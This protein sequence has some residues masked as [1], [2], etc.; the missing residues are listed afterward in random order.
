MVI[1]LASIT[2]FLFRV[3]PD[4]LR[5]QDAGQAALTGQ[6]SS[7]EE[8][9]MEGVLVSAKMTNSIVT[10]TVTSD[11]MGRYT[12]P[13]ARLQP[14]KYSLRVRAA[15]YEIDNPG[16]IEISAQKTK[17]FDLKLHKTQDLAAQLT[18]AEWFMSIP[19]TDE[20]KAGLNGCTGCQT[21]ERIMRSRY[22]AQQWPAILTRMSNYAPGAIP[23]HPQV[24]PGTQTEEGVTNSEQM[25]RRAQYLST[26]NLSS[27]RWEYVLKTLPRPKGRSTR[28]IITEYALPRANAQPHD[29]IVDKDGM[30]WY[31]DFG[32]QYIGKL[33]PKAAKA[34]EYPV[35]TVKPGFPT[36]GLDLEFDHEGNVR[37]GMM[38]QGGI[39][40]FDKKTEKFQV[41]PLPKEEGANY[42][43]QNAQVAPWWTYTDGKVWMNDVG[44]KGGFIGT[45]KGDI[46]RVDL[47]TGVWE[48]F[49]P[50]K[51]VDADGKSHFTYGIAADSH[52][53]LY[54]FD[55][56]VRNIVKDRQQDRQ[57]YGLSNPHTQ[58]DA[59]P[60]PHGL[61]GSTPVRRVS[62]QQNRDARHAERKDPGVVVANP[63]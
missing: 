30:I 42:R 48:T 9:P 46:H 62:W 29:A 55:F 33:D 25:Q 1:A 50:Y 61:A 17:Q 22:T 53:N 18:N 58:F 6:V 54:A 11:A 51:E 41:F 45:E 36:G 23:L 31:S 43:T 57:K 12:F 59:A 24:R 34:M 19:G 40:R 47:K 52:N 28:V 10:V 63:V 3:G 14:G 44:P 5:G 15:G 7:A 37:L 20:Q 13:Q 38:L 60:R 2:V 26:I 56:G 27:G 21:V 8:G 32:N 16:Q 39:G 49:D 35:P 4:A